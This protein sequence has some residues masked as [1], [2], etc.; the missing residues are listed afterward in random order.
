M[1]LCFLSPLYHPSLIHLQL[2]VV[3]EADQDWL[4]GKILVKLA[5]NRAYLDKKDH[6][7][8]DSFRILHFDASLCS[9]DDVHVNF[10]VI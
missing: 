8:F 5:M 6:V 9:P 10:Q 3:G 2:N 1:K 7:L 4:P